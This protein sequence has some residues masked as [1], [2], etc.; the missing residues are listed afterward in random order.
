VSPPLVAGFPDLTARPNII[1]V[2]T[3]ERACLAIF[4]FIYICATIQE[5]M[6]AVLRHH[7]MAAKYIHGRDIFN[8][9]ILPTDN[10]FQ[11]LLRSQL[12]NKNLDA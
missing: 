3:T 12:S 7:M 11:F 1:V 2:V 4:M 6:S 8:P 5:T 9:Q 10:S